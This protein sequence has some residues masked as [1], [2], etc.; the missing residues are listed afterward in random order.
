MHPT[1][2][3]T[4]LKPPGRHPPKRLRTND[5]LIRLQRFMTHALVRTLTDRDGL[6]PRWIDGRSTAK[7]AAE[8]MKPNDR[9]S[10]FERL[11]IYNRMYWFRVLGCVASDCPGLNA[12]L[13]DRKFGRFIR[14]YLAKYPS[15]SF[16]MR[17]LCSRMPRFIREE[18]RWTAPHT[19]LAHDIARFEWAQTVAFDGEARMPLGPSDIAG[20]APA[21]LRLGLQPYISLLA[22]EH[23]ADEYVNAVKKRVALRAEASNA[24][25]S[26]QPKSSRRSTVRRPGRGRVHVAVHRID[27]RLFYKRLEPAAFRILKA[28]G[29]GRTLP[30]AVAAG[31][32]GLA[33]EKA[34]GWFATWMKLGW[35]CRHRPGG[36]AIRR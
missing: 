15:R 1:S 12:L 8:F 18:P 35:F 23:P 4:G 5:D 24:V 28:I 6:K 3:P 21:R 13:G 30:E 25:D 36:P 33:P 9:L 14:A 20:K 22:L 32:R 19:A 34:Q 11:E 17:N 16:T 29:E 27:S 7:V 10:A 31:G 2:R 26:A